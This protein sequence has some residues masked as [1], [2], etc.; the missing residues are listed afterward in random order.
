MTFGN[1]HLTCIYRKIH[2]RL[3]INSK[4]DLDIP[5]DTKETVFDENDESHIGNGL[6]FC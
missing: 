5:K 4:E 6:F 2:M 1:K 3:Y